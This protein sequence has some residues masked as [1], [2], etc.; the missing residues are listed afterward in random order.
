MVRR[1]GLVVVAVVAMACVTNPAT[2]RSQLNM[3]SEAQEI[4]LGREADQ[5]VRAEM[6]VYDDAG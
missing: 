1:Y 2:G 3:L 5:Q 6:G 4:A